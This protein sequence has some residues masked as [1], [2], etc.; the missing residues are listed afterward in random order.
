MEGGLEVLVESSTT[1]SETQNPAE[2]NCSPPKPMEHRSL[3][4][5]VATMK[6]YTGSNTFIVTTFESEALFVGLRLV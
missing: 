1:P 6:G 5:N 2:H 3:P 4:Q